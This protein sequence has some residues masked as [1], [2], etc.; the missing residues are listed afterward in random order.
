MLRKESLKNGVR[1][2]TEYVPHVQSVSVGV[3]V[4][5]GSRHE[6]PSN[7]GISHFIEHMLFKGTS[8]RTAQQ[9]ADE[10]DSVGGQ[11][12]GFTEKEHTC[13]LAKVLS[14]YLPRSLD[15]LA[16]MLLN[17]LLA[18]KDVDLEK[19]VLLEE[20]KRHEDTSEDLVHDIFAQVAWNGHPL[21]NAIFGTTD[22][23]SALK[24][25]DLAKYIGEEYTPDR[26]VVS[27]AGN[28][29]HKAALDKVDELFG[30]MSGTMPDL[31]FVEPSFAGG[32]LLVEKSTEQ[33]QFCVGA[34]GVSQLDPDRY[35][36]AVIDTVLGSG[37]SSRLF[38]EIREKRG[39]AYAVGSYSAGYREGGLFVVFGGT[40]MDRLEEVIALIEK[41]FSCLLAEGIPEDELE[42]AKNQIRGGILLAQ[43][44]MTSR[45]MRNARTE[46][47]LGKPMPMEEVIDSVLKVSRD[48]VARVAE[49]M[50]GGSDLAVAA[51]GP[52]NG[53]KVAMTA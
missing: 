5:A 35:A 18:P 16:D 36:L 31:P 22:R 33:V 19:N 11:L 38:Q 9:I 34:R 48:D 50:F 17:S 41:E 51:V 46:M 14:E 2:L 10:F 37:M 27:V 20:I 1:L 23:V 21:G 47:Y 8:T 32:S 15:V 52:F 13:Y 39:L 29:E 26:I 6:D 42:R 24:S 7:Q 49:R 4:M 30:G 28:L 12:N 40:S 53:R 45:M 3:W 25:A 44:S 43:E